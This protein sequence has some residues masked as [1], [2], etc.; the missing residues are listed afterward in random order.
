MPAMTW[1]KLICSGLLAS[2]GIHV[3]P[4]ATITYE[5][6]VAP[7]LQRSLTYRRLRMRRWHALHQRDD[8]YRWAKTGSRLGLL[9]EV[10]AIVCF[11]AGDMIVRWSR[12]VR[13]HPGGQMQSPAS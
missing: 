7:H 3:V 10:A 9:V 2:S 11:A 12:S 1:N 8:P 5:I 4:V 13:L 6:D